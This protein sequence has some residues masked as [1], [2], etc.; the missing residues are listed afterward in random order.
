MSPENISN[1]MQQWYQLS[2]PL[3][4][5]NHADNQLFAD[6]E[7]TAQGIDLLTDQEKVKQLGASL[8]NV[9]EQHTTEAEQLAR[10]IGTHTTYNQ[11]LSTQLTGAYPS[12]HHLIS[13]LNKNSDRTPLQELDHHAKALSL[14]SE[15]LWEKFAIGT[16]K[17]LI[18]NDFV[19]PLGLKGNYRYFEANGDPIVVDFDTAIGHGK[20]GK[21]YLGQNLKTKEFLALKTIAINTVIPRNEQEIVG[22]RNLKRLRGVIPDIEKNCVY[23]AMELINGPTLSKYDFKQ[24]VRDLTLAIHLAIAY[25]DELDYV[26]QSNVNQT[27]QN[28]GNV[29]VDLKKN[30]VF[31]TD[32]GGIGLFQN[33]AFI[34]DPLFPRLNIADIINIMDLL[35]R[36]RD[37]AKENMLAGYEELFDSIKKIRYEGIRN[38]KNPYYFEVTVDELRDKLHNFL[39]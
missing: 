34:P 30:K 7:S 23:M 24:H 19:F 38:N 8:L 33:G 28:S 3:S 22:L 39:T 20:M 11:G 29:M 2:S 6:T 14:F 9:V 26:A 18:E 27:D 10:W 4:A 35:P 17:C 12:L 21:I 25:L 1:L 32:F 13:S 31:L 15:E 37:V 36:P 5:N 16:K